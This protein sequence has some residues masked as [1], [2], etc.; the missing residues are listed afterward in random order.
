MAAPRL[1]WVERLPVGAGAQPVLASLAARGV[2]HGDAEVG[3]E[4]WSL[5]GATVY[6]EKNWGKEGFP[7]AW[8]WGQ[9]QAFADPG[10]CVAFAGGQV[11]SGPLRTEVTAVVVRLPDASVIRLGNPGTSPVTARVTD[12]TWDLHGRSL[13]GWEVD[14]S[15]YAALGDAHVLPVPLPSERRNTA[16]ALE[17]LGATMSVTLRRRGVLVWE[18]RAD[19]AALEHGGLARAETE[20][21]R[22]GIP[23]SAGATHAAPRLP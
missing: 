11:H 7:D 13:A 10:A 8:W 23:A 6:G 3:D 15:G 18:G 1:R 12:T 22:R 14:I 16:G 2:V 21:R 17:H 5:D 4:R 19:L 9:A 20:L